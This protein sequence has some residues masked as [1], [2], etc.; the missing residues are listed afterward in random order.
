MTRESRD[1]QGW[2]CRH[3]VNVWD[4]LSMTCNYILDYPANL[5]PSKDPALIF[6]W[7]FH[8]MNPSFTF[9]YTIGDNCCTVSLVLMLCCDAGGIPESVLGENFLLVYTFF[10]SQYTF[11]LEYTL[12]TSLSIGRRATEELFIFIGIAFRQT[13]DIDQITKKT[14][15]ARTPSTEP[16]FSTGHHPSKMT[17]WVKSRKY[18]KHNLQRPTTKNSFQIPD[19]VPC[20]TVHAIWRFQYLPSYRWLHCIT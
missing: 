12:F 14:I 2:G 8:V 19:S 6:T 18:M 10:G 9:I 13:A 5:N 11:S 3:R 15:Q 1:K 4:Y 16:L 17:F 7:L 20:D